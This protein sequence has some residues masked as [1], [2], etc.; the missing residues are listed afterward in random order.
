MHVN[1]RNSARSGPAQITEG[2]RHNVMTRAVGDVVNSSCAVQTFLPSGYLKSLNN[3][4]I[5]NH[6][7]R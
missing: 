4:V 7:L 1:K 5:A 3:A 6:K 2:T